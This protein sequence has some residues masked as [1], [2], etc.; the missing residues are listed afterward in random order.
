MCIFKEYCQYPGTFTA[1]EHNENVYR[2]FNIPMIF[3]I[4]DVKLEFWT[5][6]IETKML[7]NL[8]LWYHFEY[9]RD[10]KNSSLSMI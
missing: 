1:M 10:H 3:K 9:L 2:V 7:N 6:L 5:V 8:A 4:Y